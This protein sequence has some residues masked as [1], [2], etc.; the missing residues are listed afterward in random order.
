MRQLW[1]LQETIC[2][3]D[4]RER[5]DNLTAELWL[6][7]ML[8]AQPTLVHLASLWLL[9]QVQFSHINKVNSNK[10][11]GVH[12]DSDL[13]WSIN[14][15][16]LPRKAQQRLLFLQR[17]RKMNP[18]MVTTF[19]RMVECRNILIHCITV[20]CGNCTAANC[21]SQWRIL[22]AAEKT[23]GISFPSITNIHTG[24]CV[25]K[26]TKIMT[27]HHLFALQPSGRRFQSIHGRSARLYNSFFPQSIR[28]LNT[29]CSPHPLH[30]HHR[31]TFVFNCVY[32]YI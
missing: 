14:T 28:I 8:C 7:S 2:L 9:C 24:R 23:T 16:A 26:A 4:L 17:L 21:R 11:P 31:G 18:T 3:W 12:V 25:R 32:F 27:S 22:R 30:H 13:N 20:W 29:K 6:P 5:N 10:F 15:A 1:K 19:Y